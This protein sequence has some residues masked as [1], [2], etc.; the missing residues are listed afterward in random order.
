[1]KRAIREHLRDFI[2]IVALI[3]AGLV[4]AG[5]ILSSQ[6]AARRAGCP[7]SAKTAS[8]SRRS[9]PRPRPS[10]GQGQAVVVA[11]IQI[12]DITGVE[13]ADGHAVVEMEIE[14]EYAP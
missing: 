9:S 5:V 4:T 11:G 13:L 12:G 14:D 1:M 6:A 7:S 2:A 10:P 3:I 8:R